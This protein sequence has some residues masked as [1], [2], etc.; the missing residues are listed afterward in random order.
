MRSALISFVFL[1]SHC[2]TGWPV[3]LNINLAADTAISESIAEMNE[4]SLT[5]SLY[6]ATYKDVSQIKLVDFDTYDLII[7]FGIRETM[8]LKPLTVSLDRCQF[9]WGLSKP[10]H[11]CSSYVRVSG[12]VVSLM[13]M[14]CSVHAVSSSSEEL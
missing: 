6:R 11:R 5:F 14:S 2:I 3:M 4:R 1:Q 9:K 8:C 13:G 12:G 10:V 7:N